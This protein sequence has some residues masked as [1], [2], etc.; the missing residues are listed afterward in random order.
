MRIHLI[1]AILA[2]AALSSHSA[3]AKQSG[4]H[5]HK[6][7]PS[8]SHSYVVGKATCDQSGC[9]TPVKRPYGGNNYWPD[10]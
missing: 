8:P 7:K 9:I 10:I 4:H 5:T 6:N 3:L 2:S 1:V